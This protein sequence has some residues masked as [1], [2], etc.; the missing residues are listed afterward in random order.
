MRGRRKTRR[1]ERSIMGI[2]QSTPLA[3][4]RC[5][6]GIK[7]FR[8]FGYTYEEDPPLVAFDE[9]AAAFFAAFSDF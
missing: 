6:D 3:H 8:V 9:A 2:Y 4:S 1:Q 7:S 5:L